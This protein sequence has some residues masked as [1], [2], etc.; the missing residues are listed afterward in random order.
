[1]FKEQIDQSI[2]VNWINIYE[3]ASEMN[4]TNRK[5]HCKNGFSYNHGLF[6]LME[7]GNHQTLGPNVSKSKEVV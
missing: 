1:M 2:Q 7:L 5:K 3:S 4:I 6:I